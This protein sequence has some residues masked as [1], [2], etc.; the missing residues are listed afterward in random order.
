MDCLDQRLPVAGVADCL[1]RGIDPA[2][3][4]GIRYDASIPDGVEQFVLADHAIAM[5]HQ[6]EQQIVD[7]G[8]H[9][10]DL[11]RTP[12]LL[13]TQV[14]LVP[15]EDDVHSGF[16]L[17]IGLSVIWAIAGHGG[18]GTVRYERLRQ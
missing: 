2:A 3:Q 15:S 9:M 14:D 10:D 17:F 7:L 12:Q 4:G 18:R 8:F 13:T 11:S 1:P 16:P 5:S 6:V